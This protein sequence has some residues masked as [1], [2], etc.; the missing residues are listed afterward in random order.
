MYYSRKMYCRF[1][2][3]RFMS[4]KEVHG[5]TQQVVTQSHKQILTLHAKHAML[6]NNK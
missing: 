4:R 3:N 6:K 2:K 5:N 1:Y